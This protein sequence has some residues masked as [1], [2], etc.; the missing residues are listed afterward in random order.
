MNAK[1]DTLNNWYSI[2]KCEYPTDYFRLI[3]HSIRGASKATPYVADITNTVICEGEHSA[4]RQI[5]K[6]QGLDCVG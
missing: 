6:Q 2:N 1:Q 4:L 5:A 3:Q